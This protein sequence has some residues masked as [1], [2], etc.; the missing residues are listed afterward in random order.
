MRGR[1]FLVGMAGAT[2]WWLCEPY[3]LN[4]AP[5]KRSP[6]KGTLKINPQNPYYFTDDDKRAIYLTGSHT[7]T[8]LQDGFVG[9]TFDFNAYLDFLAQ[10]NHNFIRMWSWQSTGAWI[11]PEI[12][13][14]PR[15]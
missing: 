13:P 5:T 2:V 8:N 9:K 11:F 10:H 1:E 3:E 15:H 7:W 14:H 4:A 6:F 12:R